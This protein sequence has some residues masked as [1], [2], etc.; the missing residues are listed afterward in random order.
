[1]SSSVP[2]NL[3]ATSFLT[4]R[5]DSKKKWR[6]RGKKKQQPLRKTYLSALSYWWLYSGLEDW[7][8]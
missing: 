6:R 2:F 3:L 4:E 7:I 1:M 8:G 5:G